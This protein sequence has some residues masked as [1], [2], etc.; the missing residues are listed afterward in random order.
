MAAQAATQAVV[1]AAAR[2][3]GRSLRSARSTTAVMA[4]RSAARA[5][6]GLPV[7]LPCVGAVP[8]PRATVL[9]HEVSVAALV[10]AQAFPYCGQERQQCKAGDSDQPDH[11]R[12]RPTFNAPS[13]RIDGRGSEGDEIA[14]RGGRDDHRE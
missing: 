1:I 3:A 11:E 13:P 8:P 9:L 12:C 5:T 14:D 6:I 4:H 2:L 10:A 7:P